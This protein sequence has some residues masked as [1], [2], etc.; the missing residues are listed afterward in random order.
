MS[1]DGLAA[2]SV[3]V[4]REHQASSGAYIAAPFP[5][6]YRNAWLRDGA[7]VADA[8]SRAGERQSAEAFFDWCAGVVEARAERMAAREILDGRFTPEGRE[9]PGRWSAAQLDGY[10][11]WVWALGG[12]VQRHGADAAPW[13]RAARLSLRYAADCW[14]TPCFDWWEERPGVHVATLA[15]LYGGLTSSLVG[16]SW[17]SEAAEAIRSAARRDGLVEGRFTARLGDGGLDASLL[18]VA[19]PFGL[20][21]PGDPVAEA[22]VRAVESELLVGRGV[23][24]HPNDEFYGGGLWVILAGLLGWHYAC[25]GRL[26]EAR[27]EL[28]WIAAAASDEG[29]LPEQL[30]GHLLHPEKQREWIE[31][32]GPPACPL[33][34]SHALF[35]TLALELG[36]LSLENAA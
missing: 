23:H 25:V 2:R 4:I 14:Q 35:L 3:A 20:V 27:A 26:E 8:M 28:N 18:A 19:T 11:L 5:P 30:D 21:E 15:A 6:A 33:L 10:G 36:A 24:R 32:W 16:E 9:V 17:A 31:R 34:W 22:T 13:L 12:H 1:L 7:F 29:D